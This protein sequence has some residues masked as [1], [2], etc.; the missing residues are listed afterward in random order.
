MI[1]IF[2]NEIKLS[3]LSYLLEVIEVRDNKSKLKAFNKIR[4]MKLTREMGLLILDNITKD[5][6]YEEDN[7]NIHLSLL[8]LLF[9]DFYLDYA[10][11]I[12]E[13]YKY[14]NDDSKYEILNILSISKNED[15]VYFYRDLVSN[16]YNGEFSLPIG[17]ISSNPN[18]YSIL[19]PELY[20]VYKLD[21]K[22]NNAI[23]IIS[24]FINMGVVPKDDLNRYK[25]ELQHSIN[26]VFKEGVN[27]KSDDKVLYEIKNLENKDSA[28]K[29]TTKTKNENKNVNINPNIKMIQS[30]KETDVEFLGNKRRKPSFSSP[31]RKNNENSLNKKEDFKTQF[32]TKKIKTKKE[33]NQKKNDYSPSFYII[34]FHNLLNIYFKCRVKYGKYFN[35][36]YFKNEGP[37]A[38]Y[39]NKNLTQ[40]NI[41]AKNHPEKLKQK[42]T[43]FI[44]KNKLEKLKKINDKEISEMLEFTVKQLIDE[45]RDYIFENAV[46]FQENEII[47]EINENLVR[48][49]RYPLK[50]KK[51]KEFGYYK[52]FE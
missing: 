40:K 1:K 15:S 26:L 23:L 30:F 9:N 8:F 47:K 17:T 27:F 25:K 34:K 35:T 52:Y 16:F 51:K 2:S 42:I 45:F 20:N 28:I 24:D 43:D 11:K 39:L 31:N 32:K 7:F 4:K 18:N 50:K 44:Q 49:R 37:N 41:G 6:L 29:S 48:I 36:E 5:K 13:L 12:T 3:K 14:L 21:L 19:F 38:Y 33:K 22:K 10:P 46:Y